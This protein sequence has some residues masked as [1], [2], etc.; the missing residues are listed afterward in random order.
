MNL[1]NGYKVMY[2]VIEDSNRV[3]KAST[4]GL[5]EDAESVA[6]YAIGAFKAIFE[7]EEHMLYGIDAE[8]AKIYLDDI[9]ALFVEGDATT[10]TEEVVE[11]NVP[12]ED[13]KTE[14]PEVVIPEE[15]TTSEE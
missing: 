12:V 4:T 2:E 9:N 5:F 3:F 1:K 8:G 10:D 7:D 6:T 14:E 13:E 15:G 11:P